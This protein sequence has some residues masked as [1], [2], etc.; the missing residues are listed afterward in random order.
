M[1][2]GNARLGAGKTKKQKKKIAELQV[3]P[4]KTKKK[5]GTARMDERTG[6]TPWFDYLKN[7]L[8]G[9]RKTKAG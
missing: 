2:V 7:S 8:P 9:I 3:K 4:G 1:D 6:V 5:R